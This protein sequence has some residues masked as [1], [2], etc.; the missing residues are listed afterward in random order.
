MPVKHT[1]LDFQHRVDDRWG[2]GA[3]QCQTTYTNLTTHVTMLCTKHN[4]TFGVMPKSVLW[5]KN[6]SPGCPQCNIANKRSAHAH[7]R[8]QFISN[9]NTVHSN[10]YDYSKVVY[11][12][13]L[14]EVEIIC[15]RHGS[16]MQRPNNHTSHKQGCPVCK[17]SRGETVVESWLVANDIPY[18][19]QKTFDGCVNKR[20]L[21]FDFYL[22]AHNTCVEFDGEQHT[23]VGKFTS[24]STMATALYER[25]K[26]N[27]AI[28]TQWCTLNNITLIRIS[29]K[30][31]N[32]VY[33]ILNYHINDKNDHDNY[34]WA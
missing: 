17:C 29:Y 13:A 28:K 33:D 32:N 25:I 20:N 6:V 10:K 18:E 15:R 7:S 2:N 3:Y 9:A 27:D 14:T 22:P 1:T 8:E 5:G 12:N 30:D 24:D 26:H 11:V 23:K 16:F 19:R 21:K 34:S 4:T 31:I